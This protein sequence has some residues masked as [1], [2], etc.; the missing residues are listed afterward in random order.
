M[1]LFYQGV[2]NLAQTKPPQSVLEY[3]N[4]LRETF[5]DIRA[6]YIFGSYAKGSAGP[7]SDIDIAV[8]FDEVED[9]FELQVQLMKIRRRYDSRIEPHVFRAGDF[10]G[11]NPLVG[12]IVSTGVEIH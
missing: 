3:V 2:Q 5:S 12:E 7:D 4:Y 11:A 10:N 6:A 8:V 1:D 9:S